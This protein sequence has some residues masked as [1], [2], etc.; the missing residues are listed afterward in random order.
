MV[1]RGTEGYASLSYLEEKSPSF[2]MNKSG[3]I[4]YYSCL[5]ECICFCNCLTLFCPIYFPG[6]RNWHWFQKQLENSR[7]T[8]RWIEAA[9]L[10]ALTVFSKKLQ[11]LVTQKMFAFV[12]VIRLLIYIASIFLLFFFE[13]GAVQKSERTRENTSVRHSVADKHKSFHYIA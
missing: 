10:R 3:W 8:E 7:D 12:D 2:S 6:Q 13:D 5:F 4:Y 11:L 1:H 9:L